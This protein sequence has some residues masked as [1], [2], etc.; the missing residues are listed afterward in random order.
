MKS[1]IVRRAINFNESLSRRF[2]ALLPGEYQVDGNRDFREQFSPPYITKGIRLVDVGGGKIPYID[3][4]TKS[5]LELHVTGLDISREE[6]DRAPACAYDEVICSDI[7]AYH[8]K[9]DSDVVVCQAV[10]EHVKDVGVA[11]ASFA[12]ILKP[13]GVALIWVPSRNA[14]FARLNLLLPETLKRK[15]LFFIYP[16]M[17]YGQGFTSYYDR[18][19]PVKFQALAARYGFVVE[20]QQLY[21]SNKYFYFCTPLHVMWRAWLLVF[22]LLRHQEAAET[23]AMALRLT[24]GGAAGAESAGGTEPA[25]ERCAHAR[26]VGVQQ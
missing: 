9:R 23:F 11:F 24:A 21:F 17:R 4:R 5:A 3:A 12:S 26:E 22:R 6:L 2:D 20:R 19:T 18:C 7:S 15:I 13:G 14:L 10:L 8:G 16:R 1:S 25:K